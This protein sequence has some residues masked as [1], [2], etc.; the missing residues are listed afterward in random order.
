MVQGLGHTS[1]W[2]VLVVV[3]IGDWVEQSWW[4]LVGVCGATMVVVADLVY[5][6]ITRAVVVGWG[7]LPVA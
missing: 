6:K 7:W 5:K 4:G 2:R 1:A 3:C